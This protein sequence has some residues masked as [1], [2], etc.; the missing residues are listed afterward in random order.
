MVAGLGGLAWVAVAARWFACRGIHDLAKAARS[1]A[2]LQGRNMVIP[3]DVQAVWSS[4]TSH[5]IGG[6][7]GVHRGVGM[8]EQILREVEV[9]T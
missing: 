6:N 8:A 3:E 7:E 5:R 2:W 1:W 9:P 4:V